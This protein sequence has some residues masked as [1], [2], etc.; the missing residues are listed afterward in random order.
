MMQFIYTESCK[1]EESD[2]DCECFGCGLSVIAD[3]TSY[4]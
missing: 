1:L 2:M 3:M 4:E